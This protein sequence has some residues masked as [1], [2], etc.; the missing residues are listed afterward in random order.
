MNTDVQPPIAKKI[1]Y[2]LEKHNDVRIDNYYWLNQREDPEVVAY[3]EKENE[4]YQ[5]MTA[6]TKKLQE[7]LFQEMKSRIKE[8]DTSVPYFYNGYY[9]ITRFETGKDYPI[10]ARKK[11]SLDAQEEIMFDCNEMAKGH[12]YFNLNGISVSEDNEWCSFG[13]DTVSRR[14]YTIKVKN[15]KT[16]EILPEAIENATGSTAWASDNK[17]FFYT[18][19]DPQTLRSDKIYKHILGTEPAKDE[20]VFHEKDD[21]FYTFVYKEKSKKYLV[22]GSTSTLTSEYQV[23]E[24]NDPSGKFRVFQKRVRGVEYSISHFGDSFYILTNKDKATNF[25]LMKTPEKATTS[26]H[27]VDL[28][29]HRK[30]VLLEGIDIFKDYLVVEERSNG[31][32]KIQI[33]PWSRE[34]PYYLPFESETYTAYTT[35]NPDFDTEL[36]R[37]AYQSLATPSSVIDFNMR[38]KEK[39]VLK[40]QEVLGG[41]FD[42]NNY[43]EERI[44]A[45]SEDGTKVPVSLVYRKGVQKDGKNPL[46]QYAYGSYGSSM[47]PWFSTTRLSLLDRGFIFAIAHIRGGEDLGR[48]WYEDG[49][50][51]KKKNTFTDFI[52]CS[53]Y[54]I[55]EG[56][57]SREHL[58]A[59]GGS[60]GGL[61]MG[62]VANMAPELYHGIIA[63]VPFVDVV[64][65]MLDDSI[66]LTTGEYDEWGNPN[67]K[68]YY[69]Y[70]L[71]YSPYDNVKTQDYPNMYISTGLHDSQVQYWE[72]AKWVAKLRDMKTDK[73]LLFLDTNMDAGHGGASGRFEAL[74][75]L[76]KEFAF[77]LDLEKIKE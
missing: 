4:Y 68:E 1:P 48:D 51:L 55:K 23:L 31:L 58:Y 9:Y 22:I 47:D 73:N 53:E 29:P 6:H 15:L 26:E 8:D 44:W 5:K 54:L 43:Q 72:P 63:Q 20:L 75:E 17:T 34:E 49:K 14:Q 70:M 74:K 57:T 7:D 21:T 66:P 27:W 39:A 19:K 65:T 2:K 18:K 61:L 32:N 40:E 77:L 37:F 16:G 59:E 38:T 10:Y 69:D 24:A 60:A 28:I 30:E 33:R 35:T 3:L 52:D 13:V 64:T 11:G 71:S 50:L 45:T 62:A 12:S 41:K 36:L 67:D 46:L 42:K 56:Y 76:A 25:K